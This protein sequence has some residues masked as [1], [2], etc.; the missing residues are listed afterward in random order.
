MRTN[1]RLDA[2]KHHE[3]KIAAAILEE[4]S[5]TRVTMEQLAEKAISEFLSRLDPDVQ[6]EI[7]RFLG[8]PS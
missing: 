5:R 4:R 1:I 8:S 7:K 2:R 6:L 3:L